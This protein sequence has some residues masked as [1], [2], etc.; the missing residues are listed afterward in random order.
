VPTQHIGHGRV[1]P[2]KYCPSSLTPV[3]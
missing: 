3:V 1:L 2:L